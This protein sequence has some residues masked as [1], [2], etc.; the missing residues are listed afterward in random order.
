[1]KKIKDFLSN[2]SLSKIID[3]L[4][5]NFVLFLF[6]F[7]WL[8][9]VTKRLW[10]TI[11]V[12]GVVMLLINLIR[13]IPKKEGK[14]S[15]LQKEKKKIEDITLSLLI[16]NKNEQL[17]LFCDYLKDFLPQITKEKFLKLESNSK[18]L[19][20]NFSSRFLSQED[21][22]KS[23][24]LA[25]KS[26]IFDLIILCINCN[27]KDKLFYE[28]LK[29]IDVKVYTIDKI[30]SE[31]FVKLQKFPQKTFE[32]KSPK[33]LK[34]KEFLRVSLDRKKAKKYFLSGLIVFFCSLITRYNIFYIVTSSLLFFMSLMCLTNKEKENS[35]L[36]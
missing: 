30:Y 27:E 7:A 20:L 18:V 34:F 19:S 33:K 8:R 35:T 36:I 32:V 23:I 2:I 26:H 9:F 3:F 31:I 10:V 22:L 21:A 17:K 25:K 13:L 14:K 1:M 6:L 29:D 24:Y 5:F 12:V 15:L 4:F 16:L 11:L 28:N